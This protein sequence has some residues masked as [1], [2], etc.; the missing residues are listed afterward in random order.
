MFPTG[1]ICQETVSPRGGLRDRFAGPELDL[2]RVPETADD[3]HHLIWIVVDVANA[4][5]LG[6]RDGGL[7]RERRLWRK[8][9]CRGTQN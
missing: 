8:R 7:R 9:D 6:P 5:V 1:A 3:R 4:S 2:D